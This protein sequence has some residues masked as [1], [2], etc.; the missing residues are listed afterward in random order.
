MTRLDA[1]LDWFGRRLAQRLD[2]PFADSDQV[3]EQRIGCSIREFFEREGEAR[4]RDLEAQVIA[5]LGRAAAG[6][7]AT[8]GGAVLRPANRDSLRAHREYDDRW[9][10][11]FLLEDIG[12]LAASM[13]DLAAALELFGAA[14]ALRDAIGAPR[15]PS[16]AQDIDRCIES[17]AASFSD[18]ERAAHRSR[19][20]ALDASAAAAR[21][22]AFCEDPHQG[23]GDR[24]HV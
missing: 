8:G 17:S 9:A 15:G 11:A 6:V 14:D 22:L 2:V 23:L 21:A 3:I 16:L 10:L 5:E 1:T 12:V 19:G 18:A 24:A 20:R 13:A 7:V 4:F